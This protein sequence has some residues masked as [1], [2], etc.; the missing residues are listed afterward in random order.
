MMEIEI[1][2]DPG[3]QPPLG[4]EA[5]VLAV[6][7]AATWAGFDRGELGVRVCGDAAIHEINRRHLGHDYPTDVISFCYGHEPP[8]LSGELIVSSEMAARQADQYGWP[9]THELL[10][11]VIHGVLHITGMDDQT[12][13]MALEMRRAE[14]A[15]LQQLGIDPHGRREEGNPTM[16]AMER[17]S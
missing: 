16:V 3:V 5:I 11:Y 9:A 12:P 6:Q 7:A 2:I 10:L 14:T 4:D 13:G 15:V 8:A 1:T 17:Q